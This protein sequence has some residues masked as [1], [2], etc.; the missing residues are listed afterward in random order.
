VT[1]AES[2]GAALQASARRVFLSLG[3]NLGDRL[4]YLRAARAALAALPEVDLLASSPIYE[5][6]PQDYEAQPAFLNQVIC[7]ETTLPPPDLLRA[8]QTIEAAHGRERSRRFGPRT[9]DI[10]ILLYEGVESDDPELTLPHPRAQQ[11]AFV[12]VPLADVWRWARGMPPFDVARRAAELAQ[13]QAV[14][15]YSDE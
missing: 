12:M 4:A 7:L 2:G 6:D 10:D 11:R 9:L 15:K 1:L 3:S 8:C 13:E 5:T 14:R